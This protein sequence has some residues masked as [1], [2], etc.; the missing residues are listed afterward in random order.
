MAASTSRA[1][2]A[3]ERLGQREDEIER[4]VLDAAVARAA[5]TALLDRRRVVRAMHPRERASSNDW[6]PSDRRFTPAARHAATALA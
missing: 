5:S 6:T 3:L 1:Q 2:V 4:Q